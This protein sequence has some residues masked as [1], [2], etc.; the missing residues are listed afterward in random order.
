MDELIPFQDAAPILRPVIDTGLDTGPDTGYQLSEIEMPAQG[1][2][3]FPIRKEQR[4]DPGQWRGR[5]LLGVMVIVI[6]WLVLAEQDIGMPD[7]IVHGRQG[8]FSVPEAKCRLYGRRHLIPPE[9]FAGYIE[10]H[11]RGSER[12][13]M[14]QV[15]LNPEHNILF[16]EATAHGG[17]VL[18]GLIPPNVKSLTGYNSARCS[19]AAPTSRE[20]ISG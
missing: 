19:S 20:T 9:E 17:V 14:Q 2:H 8:V 10:R 3:S 13:V 11:A 16:G 12:K 1:V 4:P 6:E 5:Y 15:G 7:E 18:P